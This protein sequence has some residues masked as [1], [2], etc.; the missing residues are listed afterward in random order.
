MPSVYLET[1]VISHLTTRP[2]RDLI[3]AGHQQITS[4]WW[5]TERPKFEIYISE[6]VIQEARRGDSNAAQER[7]DLLEPLAA[8]KNSPLALQLSELF[9]QKAAIP[10]TAAADSLHIAIGAING[11]DYLLT[12][13]CKHIANAIT[14]KKIEQICRERGYEP[15][16]I[17]TPE[18]LMEDN[19]ET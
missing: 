6:L 8:L 18:E 17:C 1:S 11:I 7:L 14:R 5:I 2:S 3:I 10:Q 15:S 13:N 16:V 19:D 4:E 12:W 9:L